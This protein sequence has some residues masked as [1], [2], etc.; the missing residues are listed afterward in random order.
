MI[1]GLENFIH[2]SG[3]QV[4]PSPTCTTLLL[5]SFYFVEQCALLRSS[6]LQNRVNNVHMF[7]EHAAIFVRKTVCSKTAVTYRF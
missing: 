1:A 3:V 7:T 4:L 5:E 2:K 6:Y